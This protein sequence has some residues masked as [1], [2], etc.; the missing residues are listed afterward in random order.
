LKRCRVKADLN[1]VTVEEEREEE[2]EKEEKEGVRSRGD[3]ESSEMMEEE[4]EGVFEESSI[5]GKEEDTRKKFDKVTEQLWGKRETRKKMPPPPPKP[6][7]PSNEEWMKEN[8]LMQC[9]K[10]LR[11]EITAPELK[12]RKEFFAHWDKLEGVEKPKKGEGKTSGQ[13]RRGGD[14]R[15]GKRRSTTTKEKPEK[16]EDEDKSFKQS[17]SSFDRILKDMEKK[18]KRPDPKDLA[19][20]P[21]VTWK[22]FFIMFL[23]QF[24]MGFRGII[25]NYFFPSKKTGK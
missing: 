16:D 13:K 2:E 22:M 24:I 9:L 8:E 20:S 11:G 12:R 19:K 15:G 21:T 14:E 18:R 5:G 25:W 4:P 3:G 10:L 1:D 23:F 7:R 6:V 17:G